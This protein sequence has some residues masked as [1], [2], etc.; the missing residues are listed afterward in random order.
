MNLSE[1]LTRPEV[2]TQVI[3]GI[4][5]LVES[6]VSSKRGLSG[7]AV[8]AGFTVAT[9]VKPGFIRDVVTTLLPDFA[10]ALQPV[11]DE[12]AAE[13]G[14]GALDRFSA[15]VNGN[16]RRAAEC[17]LGVTDRKIDNARPTVRKSY[18]KLRPN[19]REH[20]EAALPGLMR[21]ITPFLH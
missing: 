15:K 18:E 13:S 19:A 1:R 17:L 3:D 11:Y 7:V 14:D 16:P 2:R 8:K 9:K 6:E 10:A 5:A 20:V 12:A 21:T 4:V